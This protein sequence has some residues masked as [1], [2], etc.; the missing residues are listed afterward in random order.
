MCLD[1]IQAFQA[2]LLPVNAHQL[3]QRLLFMNAP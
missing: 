1:I 3:R 2:P